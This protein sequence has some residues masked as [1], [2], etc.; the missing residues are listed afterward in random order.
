[1]TITQKKRRAIVKLKEEEVWKK[2]VED[3][4]KYLPHNYDCSLGDDPDDEYMSCIVIEGYDDRGWTLDG[5]VIPRLAS[6]LICAK[7]IV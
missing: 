2:R 1:M 5:Y 3:V 7:E 6:G 4:C